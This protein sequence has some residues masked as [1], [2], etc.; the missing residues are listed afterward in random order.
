[1]ADRQID[2]LS[3]ASDISDATTFA[4]N[5]NAATYE[6]QQVSVGQIATFMGARA[7]AVHNLGDLHYNKSN[8][9][10][11]NPGAV[12]GWTGEYVTNANNVYPDLYTWL[13]TSHPELC[14]TRYAYDA[15]ITADG[16]CRYFVVD[17]ESGS[18]RF[19]K[20]TYT[21]PDYPWIY[22]FNAA[23]PQTTTQGAEYTTSLISKVSKAGD[24]MTGTLK[25]SG[26]NELRFGT[27]ND[28]YYVKKH[29]NG[30]LLIY[31]KDAKGLFLYSGANTFAPYYFDGT[32]GYRLLTTA[33]LS[34]SSI[35]ENLAPDYSAAVTIPNNAVYTAPA[36]GWIMGYASQGDW[37]SYSLIVNNTTFLYGGRKSYN[38][39][40]ALCFFIGKGQTVHPR[41][42]A[43]LRFV[44]C[45]G[46]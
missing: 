43:I 38:T 33:D 7:D 34:S 9:A 18:I 35:G 5:N 17:E 36:N 12:P 15:A 23:V 8:L 2:E 37:S 27:D 10:I 11:D 42:D 25:M 1:M 4:A 13:K 40:G 16:E 45:I 32:K 19:P 31:N 26:G 29:T 39:G 46:A 41:A 24:T 14:I 44:P 6:A 21:A 20:Y 28:Y 22:C 3:F 30:G